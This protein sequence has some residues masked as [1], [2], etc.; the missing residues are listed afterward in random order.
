MYFSLQK[1]RTSLSF[2]YVIAFFYN[3]TI[4]LPLTKGQANLH[5]E[6]L[7]KA[8]AK[9]YFKYEPTTSYNSLWPFYQITKSYKT[10]SYIMHPEIY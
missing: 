1:N 4:L 3:I 5:A 2:Y 10:L 8:P 7:K 9:N 6:Y